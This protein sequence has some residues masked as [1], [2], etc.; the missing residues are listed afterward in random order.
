M[1]AEL[2]RRAPPGFEVIPGCGLSPANLAALHAAVQA[3][4]YHASATAWHDSPMRFRRAG[5]FMNQETADRECRRQGVNDE[6]ARSMK[7]IVINYRLLGK[8]QYQGVF[9]PSKAGFFS[10]M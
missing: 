5:V 10:Q 3:P 1:L 9:F 2:V 4:V 7:L 6:A 8:K